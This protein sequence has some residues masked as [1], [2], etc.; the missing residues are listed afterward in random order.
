MSTAGR[1]TLS[2]IKDVLIYAFFT[3][4]PQM[5]LG[6]WAINKNH[7]TGLV[8]D[9]SNEDHCGTCGEYIEKKRLDNK[10]TENND[11]LYHFELSHMQINT[12]HK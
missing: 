3:K 5:K 2:H 11:Y 6:R 9:Y 12:P 4:N 7:R 1:V 10:T 8:V